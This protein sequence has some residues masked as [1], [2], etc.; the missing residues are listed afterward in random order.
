MNFVNGTEP[1]KIG[2]LQAYVH[3]PT[4]DANPD[5]AVVCIHQCTALG[6]SAFTVQDIAGAVAAE[7]LLV[8]SFDLRGAG[9]SRGPCCMWPLPIVSGCPEV[10]DVVRVCA[11]VRDELRRDTW[12]C[13]VSAGGPVG[14]GAVDQLE[15]IRGYTS[16]A[17]TLGLVT[18]L[19][20]LPQ[21][22]RV[23]FSD[24]PK[25][26]IMGGR[27][28]FTS[29]AAFKLWMAVARAPTTAVLVPDAGHFDLEYRPLS[30]LDA[31]LV[32]RFIAAGGALSDARLEQGAIFLAEARMWLL[33]SLCNGGPLWSSFLE[34][35]KGIHAAIPYY[36][37][38]KRFKRK[39]K[40]T[41]FAWNTAAI[42]GSA[43]ASK[44][45]RKN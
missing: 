24:K 6:G 35:H 26:F 27:D 7:G 13:G 40:E 38:R 20:F 31:R 2:R 37:R 8:V 18:S 25:L 45:G 5:I 44:Q 11:W 15:C 21:T 19:L 1:V 33:Q 3:H 17:Y 41:L 4:R 34:F 42:L 14:A 39:Q 36:D 29:I 28:M 10:S 12:I 22:L 23:V 30:R 32:V 9:S 43:N 16:I